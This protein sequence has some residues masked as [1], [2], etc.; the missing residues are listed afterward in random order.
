LNGKFS[1]KGDTLTYLITQE[2][3]EIIQNLFKV[4]GMASRRHKFDVEQILKT[5]KKIVE[6]NVS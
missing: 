5:I 1:K 3:V 6:K 4:F 2:N